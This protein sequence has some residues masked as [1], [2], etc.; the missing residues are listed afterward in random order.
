MLDEPLDFAAA[1][2]LIRT[3][4]AKG[5]FR[6]T[7]HAL[8][9]LE[10]DDLQEVDAVNVLRA[11]VVEGC[12]FERGSWRYRVRT[13]RITVVVAFRSETALVVVTGWRN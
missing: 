11:G 6:L 4:L 7:S 8:D 9:E 13:P 5:E 10:N 12:D 1:K 3:I 2:A